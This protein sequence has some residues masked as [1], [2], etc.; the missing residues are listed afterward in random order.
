MDS[1]ISSISVDCLFH[2]MSKY[3]FLGNLEDFFFFVF[4]C[5]FFLSFFLS[6]IYSHL[7]VFCESKSI[8]KEVLLRL[9]SWWLI[10]TPKLLTIITSWWDHTLGNYVLQWVNRN[11]FGLICIICVNDFEMFNLILRFEISFWHE[12]CVYFDVAHQIV[13]I[14]YYLTLDS[15]YILFDHAK[16]YF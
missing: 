12:F 13:A 11:R 8:G 1:G 5:S 4:L 15:S 14:F 10:D 16:V 3:L 9:N 2:F 7:S 6:F